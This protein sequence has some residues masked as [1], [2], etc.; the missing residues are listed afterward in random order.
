MFCVLL[1]RFL[2]A[3]ARL[4]TMFVSVAT[5]LSTRLEP[6]FTPNGVT[7]IQKFSAFIADVTMHE[8]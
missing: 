6:R 4:C 7:V 3:D 5:F 2:L 1:C 8:M